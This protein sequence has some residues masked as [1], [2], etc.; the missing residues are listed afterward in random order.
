MTFR[1][2]RALALPP[3]AWSRGLG[4]L[5]WTVIVVER[6]GWAGLYGAIEPPEPL[7]TWW[8]VERTLE[9]R[10]R[11]G[12]TSSGE[13]PKSPRSTTQ[14]ATGCHGR[15]EEGVGR[16]CWKGGSALEKLGFFVTETAPVPS[17]AA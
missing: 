5:G 11:Q 6:E 2:H 15:N 7:E 4:G 10:P 12:E 3:H 17:V 1:R 14:G 9:S 13:P 16:H 8:N